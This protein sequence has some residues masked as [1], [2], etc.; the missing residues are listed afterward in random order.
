MCGCACTQ[1]CLQVCA[2]TRTLC[3]YEYLGGVHAPCVY[4]RG[5]GHTCTHATATCPC[6]GMPRPGPGPP[7]ERSAVGQLRCPFVPRQQEGPQLGWGGCPH[8]GPPHPSSV[9]QG[10]CAW[11]CLT[12][13]PSTCS[14]TTTGPTKPG[15]RRTRT[16]R[17][18]PCPPTAT[19]VR[20]RRSP[21][22]ARRHGTGDPHIAAVGP[23]LVPAAR[24]Q[25]APATMPTLTP[26]S[27]SLPPGRGAGLLFVTNIDSS[28]P[29]QLVY[30]T[31][32]PSEKVPGAAGDVAQNSYLGS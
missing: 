8:P 21:G 15:A 2:R 19:S 25:P 16:P 7:G 13:A 11:S 30:K 6:V 9:R 28:D 10:T 24:L 23:P 32:E 31:P 18:S 17:S 3:V 20:A 14:A 29:D 22:T 1:A 5:L 27:L 12:R 4:M 26:L